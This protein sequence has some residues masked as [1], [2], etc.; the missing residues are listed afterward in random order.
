[1]SRRGNQVKAGKTG[2][3]LRIRVTP[4]ARKNEISGILGDGT[5]K[6]R[7]TAPPV[8]G[9]AN[10]ALIRFLAEVLEVSTTKIE[11]IG[12]GTARIKLVSLIGFDIETAQLRILNYLARE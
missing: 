3:A 12:G 11:I 2:S 10:E 1:M 4:R 7:L 5:I 8:E 9:K 6:V